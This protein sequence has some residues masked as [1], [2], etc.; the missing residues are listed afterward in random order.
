ML[1]ASVP[2]LPLPCLFFTSS[3][4]LVAI[5]NARSPEGGE[6][7]LS[8]SITERSR[9]VFGKCSKLRTDSS[10][11]LAAI[12][13]THVRKFLIETEN[14]A[15]KCSNQPACLGRPPVCR[16][17]IF[18]QHTYIWMSH[19]WEIYDWANRRS[20]RSGNTQEPR[21]M[22]THQRYRHKGAP[23]LADSLYESFE[24]R[25]MEY[26]YVLWWPSGGRTLNLLKS[27]GGDSTE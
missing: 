21:R 4:T 15:W 25:G 16:S 27:K 14:A 9:L 7:S 11:A 2:S 23:L 12:V 3:I 17:A 20:R 8:L 22:S 5:S 10:T 1:C 24:E 18:S 19:V 13:T 6:R 26:K